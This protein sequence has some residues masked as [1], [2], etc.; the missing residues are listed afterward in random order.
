M[1]L[2][3]NKILTKLKILPVE[4]S[5]NDDF[6]PSKKPLKRRIPHDQTIPLKNK[7]ILL[8]DNETSH[9]MEQG[10]NQN[11]NQAEGYSTG[12]S[13]CSSEKAQPKIKIHPFLREI[14]GK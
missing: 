14:S 8:K 11:S 5:A 13:S 6:K 1:N 12:S 9:L 2:N 7:S 10:C 3:L 4:N